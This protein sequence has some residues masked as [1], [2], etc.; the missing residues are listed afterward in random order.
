MRTKNKELKMKNI[1]KEKY[2]TDFDINLSQEIMNLERFIIKNPVGTK[3]F[4]SE[5]QQRY[6]EIIATKA[7][8]RKALKLYKGKISEEKLFQLYAMLEAYKEILNYLDV[9]R[10]LAL[11]LNSLETEK[12]D[13]F[14]G[15]IPNEEIDDFDEDEEW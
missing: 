10:I 9:L 3:E 4:W 6:G 11:K 8:I 13:L 7:A 2:L 12:W 1:E 14:E 15:N 5:W